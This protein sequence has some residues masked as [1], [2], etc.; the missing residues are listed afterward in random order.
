MM[1]VNNLRKDSISLII[2]FVWML[3]LSSCTNPVNKGHELT[4][5]RIAMPQD[6][7]NP[8]VELLGGVGVGWLVS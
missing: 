5:K 7:N 4:V 6:I 3:V 1:S 2:L 8:K